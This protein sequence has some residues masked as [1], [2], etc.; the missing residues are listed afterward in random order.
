[1]FYG[2]YERKVSTMA[3]CKLFEHGVTTNDA[4]LVSVRIRDVAETVQNGNRPRTRL[5]STGQQQWV[6]VPG[7]NRFYGR[8]NFFLII[9]CWFL[10][11]NFDSSGKNLQTPGQRTESSER[12][13]FI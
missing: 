1:M 11:S 5:S 8:L 6:D 2:I 7:K 9:L 10:F 12:E 13:Y 3:L 4:R